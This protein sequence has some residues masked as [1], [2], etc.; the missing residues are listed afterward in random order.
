M[1]LDEIIVL[2]ISIVL[3]VG[4]VGLLKKLLKDKFKGIFWSF[5]ILTVLGY[6]LM[7]FT[8]ESDTILLMLKDVFLWAFIGFMFF[9][10]FYCIVKGA[11]SRKEHGKTFWSDIKSEYKNVAGTF[12]KKRNVKSSKEEQNTHDDE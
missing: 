5:P 11:K 8:S 4:I 10:N 2:I 12:K 6:A 7:W 9:V 1:G 3:S